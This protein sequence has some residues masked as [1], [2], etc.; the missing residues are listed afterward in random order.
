[1]GGPPSRQRHPCHDRIESGK[2][3]SFWILSDADRRTAVG[4]RALRLHA[5]CF[6]RRAARWI[7][8]AWN[9]VAHLANL[10]LE[11]RRGHRAG[12]AS[13]T[14]CSAK[15]SRCSRSADRDAHAL[16]IYVALEPVD[17]WMGAERL[18]AMAR[19]RM[20]AEPRSR[21]CS[22]LSASV[23]HRVKVLTCDGTGTIPVSDDHTLRSRLTNSPDLQWHC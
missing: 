17:K 23:G 9:R 20:R 13:T 21:A 12:P 1:M 18:G 7:S 5:R 11:C 14:R 22:S 10:L 2:I 16:P 3:R 6:A 8:T 15:S 19:E 4:Q